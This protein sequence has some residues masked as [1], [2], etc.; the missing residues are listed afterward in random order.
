MN[1]RSILSLMA[2][3]VKQALRY[4]PTDPPMDEL[5]A[6]EDTILRV[7]EMSTRPV[8]DWART[9]SAQ[10]DGQRAQKLDDYR[11]TLFDITFILAR[12]FI[13]AEAGRKVQQS[14]GA[15]S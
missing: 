8:T 14:G 7:L 12:H 11:Q 1:A 13:E 5:E 10:S 2:P 15:T 4:E 9:G 3:A 6:L